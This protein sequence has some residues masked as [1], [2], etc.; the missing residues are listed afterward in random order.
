MH[1]Q[2]KPTLILII[3]LP[4]IVIT[5]MRMIGIN[6]SKL[7]NLLQYLT[8]TISTLDSLDAK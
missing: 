2:E 7:D 5:Y 3:N 1:S 8:Q 4:H 6:A